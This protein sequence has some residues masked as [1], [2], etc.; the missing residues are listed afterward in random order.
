MLDAAAT[1]EETSKVKLCRTCG[2]QYRPQICQSHSVSNH[3]RW[4]WPVLLDLRWFRPAIVDVTQARA[5]PQC[6]ELHLLSEVL[7]CHCCSSCWDRNISRGLQ[8]HYSKLLPHI[9]LCHMQDLTENVLKP[10]ARDVAD[11]LPGAAERL[12]EKVKANAE[13]VVGQLQSQV[14]GHCTVDTSVM[15]PASASASASAHAPCKHH[16]HAMMLIRGHRSGRQAY[17][18]SAV[19]P[20]TTSG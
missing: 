15:L 7:V 3:P 14:R 8:D 20:V 13:E 4:P 17:A 10:T 2:V 9:C 12:N 16:H 19:W 5:Q 6:C 11:K 1:A 18:S